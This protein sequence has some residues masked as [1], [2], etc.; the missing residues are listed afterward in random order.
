MSTVA[1]K[2]SSFSRLSDLP[3]VASASSNR[4]GGECVT[5]VVSKT[6]SSFAAIAFLT[7]LMSGSTRCLK[8]LLVSQTPAKQCPCWKITT[9][10]RPIPSSTEAK[11]SVE[12]R[13]VASPLCSTTEGRRVFWP[14][15]SKLL[16]GFEYVSFSAATA[17]Q[18]AAASMYARL[19]SRD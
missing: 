14:D 8:V 7:S 6:I 19:R 9:G 2:R 10:F 11:S 18:A 5:R 15:F 1:T 17:D 13:Q 3:A 12:S 16:G 4:A